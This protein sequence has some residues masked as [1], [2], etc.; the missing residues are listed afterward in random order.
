[1]AQKLDRDSKGLKKF[2]MAVTQSCY[3]LPLMLAG[4]H[5]ELFMETS[6]N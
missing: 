2:W 5:N 6:Q 1:M 3:D 4:S